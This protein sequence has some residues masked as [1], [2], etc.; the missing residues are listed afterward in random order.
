MRRALRSLVAIAFVAGV[1]GLC[2]LLDSQPQRTTSWPAYVGLALAAGLV[3]IG[4]ERAAEWI[5]GD[6]RVSD[7][8]PR[9][10]VRLLLL[11]GCAAA[12]MALLYW[13]L[14]HT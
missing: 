1:Y 7:P 13:I 10:V 8:L 5:S 3:L 11:L 6:D 14:S 12:T 9:R 2:A 4:G